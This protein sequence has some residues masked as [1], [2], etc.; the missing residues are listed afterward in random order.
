MAEGYRPK[1]GGKW[2]PSGVSLIGLT[3][4]TGATGATGVT[5]AT[6]AT[7]PT[8]ATGATGSYATAAPIVT[9]SANY[10]VQLTDHRIFCNVTGNDRTITMPSAAAGQGRIYMIRRVGTGSNNCTVTP[11]AGNPVLSNGFLDIQ[12]ITLTSDGTNW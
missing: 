2:P 4:A 3:G 7:G 5:G 8:G 10:S 6:G 9:V 1:A 12:G 11:V